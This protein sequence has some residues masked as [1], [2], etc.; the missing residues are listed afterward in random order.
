MTG[1]GWQQT[2]VR[3][4]TTVLTLCM[5]AVIFAFSTQDA[6]RSDRTSGFISNAI[7]R[8]LYPNYPSETPERQQEIYDSVQHVVRKCAGS[9]RT[10]A[11]IPCWDS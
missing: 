6:D 4:L 11:N 5:M 10:S 9:A 1:T 3:I 2:R 8:V 7:I